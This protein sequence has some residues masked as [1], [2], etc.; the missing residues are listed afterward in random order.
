MFVKLRSLVHAAPEERQLEEAT[1]DMTVDSTSDSSDEAD[2][3]DDGEETTDEDRKYMALAQE[4]AKRS[5]DEQTKVT[6]TVNRLRKGKYITAL[7][8]CNNRK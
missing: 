6:H 3:G 2:M 4:C 7:E 5:K 1:G 8:V